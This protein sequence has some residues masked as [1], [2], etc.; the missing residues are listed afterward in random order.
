MKRLLLILAVL[1]AGRVCAQNYTRDAG[2]RLGDFYSASYRQYNETDE[3]VE[4]LLFVGRHSITFTLMKEYF[5][6][7]FNH[8]SDNLWF[9]YGFGA[10]VGF[11]YTD[12]YQ[13]LNRTYRLEKNTFTPLLGI[14]GLIGLE[15]HFP[16]FP[17]MVGI[18]MKPYFEYSTTPIFSIYLQSVGVSLKYR[19]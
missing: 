4:A 7:V 11:R 3:A 14:D 8:M 2:V 15:Y 16:E 9:Q 5:L 18:D 17:F 1:L 12:S 19:F 10:H 6:P 13:V